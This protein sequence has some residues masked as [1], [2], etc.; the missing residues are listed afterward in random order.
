MSQGVG[1]H[2]CR[3]KGLRKAQ[4]LVINTVFWHIIEFSPVDP[5]AEVE[6]RMRGADGQPALVDLHE[7]YLLLRHAPWVFHPVSEPQLPDQSQTRRPIRL[8]SA[9]HT[10]PALPSS[11]QPPQGLLMQEDGACGLQF[12]HA[13]HKLSHSCHCALLE[14][15]A[16]PVNTCLS[17]CLV[18]QARAGAGH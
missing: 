10:S 14:H 16:R 8:L 6:E 18:I 4:E 15:A 5:E 1:V 3:Y 12:S 2:W 17:L 13:P 7:K 9:P 11:S